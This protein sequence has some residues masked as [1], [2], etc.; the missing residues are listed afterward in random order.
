MSGTDGLTTTNHGC[1]GDHQRKDS[2]LLDGLIIEATGIMV[3]LHSS[4]TKVRG[5]D[6]KT[7]N[8][9]NMAR[10]FPSPQ[11]SPPSQDHAEVITR[12]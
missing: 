4:T 10:L 7:E 2:L 11:Q 5:G 9:S 3:V 8:G 12:E 1:T 6:M